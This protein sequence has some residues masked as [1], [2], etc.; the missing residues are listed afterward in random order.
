MGFPTNMSPSTFEHSIIVTTVQE[1]EE[2]RNAKYAKIAPKSPFIQ[3]AG[4][5]SLY[6]AKL[7]AQISDRKHHRKYICT[8]A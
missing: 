5:S 1:R 7:V 4:N 3:K 8:Q 6:E 2:T